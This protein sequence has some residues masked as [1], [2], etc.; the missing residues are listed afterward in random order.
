MS[1]IIVQIADVHPRDSR[2]PHGV[3]LGEGSLT[4]VACDGFYD[5]AEIAHE[6]AAIVAAKHPSLHTV[7]A[8][9]VV[10]N[11]PLDPFSWGPQFPDLP[12]HPN[13]APPAFKDKAA[14][15]AKMTAA[16]R[17]EIIKRD[18]Y[19][20]RAC[21]FAVQDGARLHVDHIQAVSKG[22][23]TEAKNLQTLCAACNLGKGAS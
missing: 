7:V 17:Y 13:E 5:N 2:I 6:V 18:G 19:R 12:V 11:D 9:V 4:P 15:R 16:L 23:K 10:S 1:F 20:C 3:L 21:G 22:G 8:E 14:E